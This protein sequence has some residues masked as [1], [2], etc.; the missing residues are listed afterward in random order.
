MRKLILSI[1]LIGLL[2][3][4]GHHISSQSYK[5]DVLQIQ[6]EINGEYVGWWDQKQNKILTESSDNSYNIGFVGGVITIS[7]IGFGIYAIGTTG[8][9][10][11]RGSTRQCFK[12]DSL[13]EQFNSKYSDSRKEKD[14]RIP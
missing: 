9:N 5:Y 2:L 3:P 14:S 10:R 7:I 8:R 1:M 4:V 11:R 13:E 12:F 6:N